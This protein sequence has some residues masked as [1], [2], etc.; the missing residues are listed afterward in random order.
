MKTTIT[1]L[2]VIFL[3]NSCK[4]AFISDYSFQKKL[5]D[6]SC[7]YAIQPD[8]DSFS[9]LVPLTHTTNESVMINNA[10]VETEE[11]EFV[12]YGV[13]NEAY[14][15]FVYYMEE[16]L[17]Q[18]GGKQSCGTIYVTRI[19]HQQNLDYRPGMAAFTLLIPNL[20]GMPLKVSK[21]TNSY[22]FEVYSQA[23]ELIY[24]NKHTGYGKSSL[25]LYYGFK[26]AEDKAEYEATYNAIAEFLEQFEEEIN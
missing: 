21:V 24:R 18:Q 8:E 19:H 9:K 16:A 13:G 2:A 6:N 25:G 17:N 14:K 10:W 22:L 5:Q 11:E 23:D 26:N 12:G 3:L 4:T 7:Y 20:L 15:S 1:L